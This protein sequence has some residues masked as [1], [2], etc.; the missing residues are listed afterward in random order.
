MM[1]KLKHMGVQL[2]PLENIEPKYWMAVKTVIN[3]SAVFQHYL[4]TEEHGLTMSILDQDI[5]T[6]G[7]Y[8]LPVKPLDFFPETTGYNY[9]DEVLR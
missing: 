5:V 2:V 4:L 6:D 8:D 9:N 3:G 7:E 1:V